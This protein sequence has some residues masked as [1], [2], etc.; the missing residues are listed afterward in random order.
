[1]QETPGSRRRAIP[2]ERLR[3]LERSRI[4]LDHRSETGTMPVYGLDPLDVHPGEVVG[5]RLLRRQRRCKIPDR[6]LNEPRVGC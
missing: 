6:A 3:D 2:V 5:R 4:C 1:V